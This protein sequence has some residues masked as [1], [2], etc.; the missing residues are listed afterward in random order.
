MH[1]ECGVVHQLLK[2]HVHVKERLE[3]ASGVTTLRLKGVKAK[4]IGVRV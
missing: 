4:L 1:L 3:M 2:L